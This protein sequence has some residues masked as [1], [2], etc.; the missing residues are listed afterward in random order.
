MVVISVPEPIMGIRHHNK[1]QHHVFQLINLISL[2]ESV[3]TYA[4][5]IQLLKKKMIKAKMPVIKFTE[6]GSYPLFGKIVDIHITINS[7][8]SETALGV[9]C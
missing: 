7:S 1:E 8:Y 9:I 2:L 4:L 5:P 6:S 3:P